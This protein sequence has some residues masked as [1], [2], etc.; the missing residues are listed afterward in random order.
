MPP[1]CGFRSGED[2]RST[3]RCEDP[4][5]LL[6]VLGGGCRPRPP[7]VRRVHARLGLDVVGD[8]VLEDVTGDPEIHGSRRPDHGVPD[9]LPH[10]PRHLR[11]DGR[12]DTPLRHRGEQRNLVELLVLLAEALRSTHRRHQ[13]DHRAGRPQRLR[14]GSRDVRG[15]GPDTPRRQRSAGFAGAH[16]RRPCR[17]RSPRSGREPAECPA[18]STRST[19]CCRGRS[20]GRS[21]RPPW[22]GARGQWRARRW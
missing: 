9:R 8:L 12:L 16:T 15:A 13:G 22:H 7:G 5:G 21:A 10:E 19:T 17:R 14:Q 11:R 20:S 18:I 6:G 2:H 1:S 3:R 4:H